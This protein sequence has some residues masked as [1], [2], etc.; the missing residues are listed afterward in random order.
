MEK[1]TIIGLTIAA[2][3]LVVSAIILAFEV[4]R[5]RRES[6]AF[7]YAVTICKDGIIVGV[8]IC[9][10]GVSNA[11]NISLKNIEFKY[12]N[13]PLPIYELLPADY[14]YM[15]EAHCNL[16]IPILN[17]KDI[18]TIRYITITWNDRCYKK[19]KKNSIKTAIL[20]PVAQPL[21]SAPA[22][23]SLTNP[24]TFAAK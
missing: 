17:G 19:K 2:S 5:Y 16:Y 13:N 18:K 12:D 8:K 1:I 20:T 10:A 15:I 6:K 21:T 23:I 24:M 14:P 7:L 9:N 4:C 3:S 22:Y 11:W